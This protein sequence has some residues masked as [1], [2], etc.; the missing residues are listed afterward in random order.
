MF[1]LWVLSRA[2]QW[3]AS[4]HFS[5]ESILF[6]ITFVDAITVLQSLRQRLRPRCAGHSR[7]RDQRKEFASKKKLR[8]LQPNFSHQYLW[9]TI[10][11]VRPG[12]GTRGSGSDPRCSPSAQE[13]EAPTTCTHAAPFGGSGGSVVAQAVPAHH[14]APASLCQSQQV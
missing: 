6:F 10:L 3:F 2:C 7:S 11:H 9:C 13:L 12:M 5:R 14:R 4:W 8:S 1:S